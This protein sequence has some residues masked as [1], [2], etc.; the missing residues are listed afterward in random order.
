MYRIVIDQS[1]SASKAMLFDEDCLISRVDK[2]HE[3][4]YPFEGYVEHNPNEI[5]SNVKFII[6]EII[7]QNNLKYSD[8]LSLSITNQR[9]TSLAWKKS[10]G[11]PIYNAIVW[12]CGRTSDYCKEMQVHNAFVNKITGLRVDNYFS[13]PKFNWIMSNVEEARTL[14]EN[15]DLCLG[16]I[17]SWLIYHLSEEKNF[18][19]DISNASRTLLMDIEKNEWS[20][21]MINLFELPKS[22][23]AQ[24]KLPDEKFGHYKGIPIT[25]VIADSQAALYAQDLK[26]KSEV[27]VTMGTGSSIMVNTEEESFK[28]LTV[29]TALYHCQQGKNLY[30]L[31][32]IIKSFGDT[33]EFVKENLE[34]FKNYNAIFDYTFSKESQGGIIYIPGQY[35][36]GCPYWKEDV[37]CHILGLSRKSKKED[38][39][40]AAIKSLAFQIKLVIDEL[41][42]ILNTTITKIKVDGGMS[43]QAVFVQFIAN[44]TQKEIEILDIEEASAFGA[45]KVI[46]D[47]QVK[48]ENSRS[49]LAQSLDEIEFLNYEKWKDMLE[50]LLNEN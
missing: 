33:I 50:L 35:G 16:T 7:R 30:A 10:S 29:L 9:E 40:A 21:E 28:N 20:Q 17:E 47:Y 2:K 26:L 46:T 38:I 42:K 27:K 1:T 44:L 36:L 4:I 18:F 22:A 13:A 23:L 14:A 3:Q 25:G 32:G 34:T 49:F 19:T 45:L 39:A 5:V 37:G 15:E 6:E 11:R 41:E 43:K 12:Q 24:I 8:I 48:T 31:E